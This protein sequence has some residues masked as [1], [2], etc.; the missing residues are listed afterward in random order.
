MIKYFD[1][2]LIL[3][4]A[5]VV[6][7]GPVDHNRH[8]GNN[9]SG[10]GHSNKKIINCDDTKNGIGIDWNG[11]DETIPEALYQ[12]TKSKFEILDFSNSKALNKE[13]CITP[14]TGSH[15]CLDKKI[16]YDVQ[17][18]MGGKHRPV[19]VTYGE[20]LYMPPQRWIHAIE[21]GAA[22]FLFNPCANG[23]EIEAFKNISKRCLRRHII[24]PYENL[25]EN[26]HF[27]IVTFG[28]RVEMNKVI[29]NEE[30]IKSYLRVNLA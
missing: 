3:I 21:H 15:V 20:Y 17:I 18:P 13:Y 10:H 16:E 24:T 8:A 14:P 7:C 26:V 30:I 12:C 25:P 6:S 9:P 11:D 27:A 1:L 29:D 28:C 19:W 4:I 23:A 22:A 2:A 5:A